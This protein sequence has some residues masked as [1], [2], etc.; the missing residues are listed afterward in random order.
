MTLQP[1]MPVQLRRVNKV[2]SGI[3]RWERKEKLAKTKLTKLR[4]Q[5][6]YYRNKGVAL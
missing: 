6:A 4:R 5:L 1:K 3:K 2:A